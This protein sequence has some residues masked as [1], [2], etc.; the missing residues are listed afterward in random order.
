MLEADVN[1]FEKILREP[2]KK[3]I[4]PCEIFS[5]SVRNR[6][7]GIKHIFTRGIASFSGKKYAILIR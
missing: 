7:S 6:S 1:D 3:P 4:V 5:R 2:V